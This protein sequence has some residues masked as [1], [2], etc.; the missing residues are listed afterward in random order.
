MSYGSI[1]FNMFTQSRK[2]TEGMFT[3]GM[4][5]NVCWRRFV[6]AT[7]WIPPPTA[8]LDMFFA[9][10]Q[11]VEV[12]ALP[13]HRHPAQLSS[14]QVLPQCICRLHLFTFCQSCLLNI[15]LI[16]SKCLLSLD[17][18][19]TLP[20]FPSAIFLC[21]PDSECWIKLVLPPLQ[22]NL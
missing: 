1:Q 15:V 17:W 19:A 16:L 2:Y 8:L 22:Y 3:H 21:F 5:S 6:T 18:P 11:V 12:L 9:S 20:F 7:D 14:P 10:G 4:K 13:L